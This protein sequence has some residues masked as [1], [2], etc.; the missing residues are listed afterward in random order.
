MGVFAAAIL[1]MLFDLFKKLRSDPFLS[2]CA[3]SGL[4]LVNIVGGYIGKGYMDIPATFFCFSIFYAL[5][6]TVGGYLRV[7]PGVMLASVLLAGSLLIKQTGLFMLFPFAAACFFVLRP[8]VPDANGRKKLLIAMTGCTLLLAAPWYVYKEVQIGHAVETSEVSYVTKDIYA[9]K[10]KMQ[11]L[12]DASRRFQEKV[13][14][15]PLIDVLPEQARPAA[16]LVFF[17]V[18]IILTIASLWTALGRFIL[19]FVVVPYYFIWAVYFSYDARNAALLIPFWGISLGIGSV[20]V[21]NWLAASP[22]TVGRWALGSVIGLAILVCCVKFP[23][24]RLSN[25]ERRMATEQLMDSSM[26]RLLYQHYDTDAVKRKTLC[27]Y[28]MMAYLPGIRQ[29][30]EPF[31][32]DEEHLEKLKA[33]L[34]TDTSHYQFCILPDAAPPAIWEYFKTL[35]SRGYV[36][37]RT[38][39][40]PGWNLIEL[41]DKRQ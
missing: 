19:L 9:G 11:R 1:L 3:W 34:A 31:S 20:V 23:L 36:K 38:R 35:E 4:L 14:G 30:A 8:A 13:T 37:S 10:D 41:N 2:A 6:L 18:L 5:L 15:T 12:H 29:F 22:R 39:T 28:P 32:F 16:S 21:T 40:N 27:A 26:N 17:A 33:L 24:E 7:F 25:L